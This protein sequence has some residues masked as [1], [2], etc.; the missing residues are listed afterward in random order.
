MTIQQVQDPG[1]PPGTPVSLQNVVV[2]A[3]DLF[4]T[5]TGDFWV[6][7]PDGGPLSGVLVFPPSAALTTVASLTPGDIVTITGAEKDEFALTGSDSRHDRPHRHRA[8]A[9]RGGTMTIKKT[10]TGSVPAP[11]SN[12]S[13][14]DRQALRSVAGRDQRRRR[15][16]QRGVADVGR[17]ARHRDERQRV[18]RAEIV[19]LG[20]LGSSTASTSPATGELEGSLVD[21]TH[22]G[23]AVDTCLATLT[24]VVDY[25]YQFLIYPRTA[26]TSRREA[27]AACS[28]TRRTEPHFAPTASTTTATGSRTART[29]AARSARMRISVRADVRHAGGD[30]VRLFGKLRG[31]LGR[32]GEQA[33]TG[34]NKRRWSSTT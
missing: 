12:G 29:S 9:D 16:V 11:S 24:G 1:T 13:R 30:D 23:I 4:G 19:R 25:F 15:G 34:N 31:G 17:R 32:R 18:Q 22:S 2:T 8:R 28:R 26:R 5:R 27:P 20:W 10:S 14:R 21:I 33:A 7:E 6:E 3:V